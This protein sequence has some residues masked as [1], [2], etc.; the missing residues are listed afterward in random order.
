MASML[1]SRVA[2]APVKAVACMRS[3]M[4]TR[5]IAP[6]TARPATSSFM[7]GELSAA[8]HLS[9]HWPRPRLWNWVSP[10]PEEHSLFNLCHRSRCEAV[11]TWR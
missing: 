11:A 7:G 4:T 2:A 5:A 10:V 8:P 6:I 1:M 9:G 3:A